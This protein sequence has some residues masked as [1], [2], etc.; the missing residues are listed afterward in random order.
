MQQLRFY[1]LKKNRKELVKR[2]SQMLT[3]LQY[4]NCR[5]CL[6]YYCKIFIKEIELVRLA[7]QKILKSEWGNISQKHRSNRTKIRVFRHEYCLS[8]SQPTTYGNAF[9][10]CVMWH[11][12]LFI[13]TICSNYVKGLNISFSFMLI[14]LVLKF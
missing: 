9:I 1:I 14:L 6:S 7:T 13:S 12:F 11:H 10:C 5:Y 2:V 4:L 3:M 8:R